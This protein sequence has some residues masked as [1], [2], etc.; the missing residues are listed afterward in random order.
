[1]IKRKLKAI[2]L[3][4]ALSVSTVFTA[5]AATSTTMENSGAYL[6]EWRPVDCGRPFLCYFSRWKYQQ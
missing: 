1:M 2:L 6:F 3:A 4:A 5:F